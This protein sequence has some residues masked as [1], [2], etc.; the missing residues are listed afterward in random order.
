MAK[1]LLAPDYAKAFGIVLVVFG[2]TLRGLFSAEI[3]PQNEFWSAVDETVYLFH[4]PL[5]FYI[6][7]LFVQQSMEHYG[8]ASFA[9][10]AFF[11]LIPPLVIW[12][13]MQFSLQYLAGSYSNAHSDF[14]RLL[15]APV[16]PR[17]QFWFLGALF[18][19]M[20]ATGAIVKRGVQDSV[21][22]PLIM[23]LFAVQIMFWD[24][25]IPYMIGRPWA[26]L[27]FSTLFFWPFFLLGIVLGTQKLGDLKIHTAVCAISFL[28]ALVFYQWADSLRAPLSV[29]CVLCIYKIALN[30]GQGASG[31]GRLSQIVAFVGMNSMMIYLAHIIFSAGMRVALTQLGIHDPSVHL[32]GGVLA[33]LLI[34]LMLVPVGMFIIGKSPAIGRAIFPVRTGRG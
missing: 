18:M 10:R 27:F 19:M 14:G 9:K 21:I 11:L 6:S 12:S 2:H 3:L 34:P 22:W 16:P 8:Y 13:Y 33:G 30:L 17:Q 24:E 1:V 20:I 23:G 7:G 25:A 15:A 4:M 29:L 5:F 28:L 32:A 26:H 31:A